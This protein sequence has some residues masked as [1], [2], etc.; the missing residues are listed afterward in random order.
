MPGCFV[1][2]VLDCPVIGRSLPGARRVV[3]PLRAPIELG[4]GRDQLLVYLPGT[5]LQLGDAVPLARVE[6]LFLFCRP[7]LEAT[8]LRTIDDCLLRGA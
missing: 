3:D 4:K 7:V 8:A 2:S 6:A 1:A 5:A